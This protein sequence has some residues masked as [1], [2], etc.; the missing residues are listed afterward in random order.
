MV[1]QVAG[2][3]VIDDSRNYSGGAISSTDYHRITN[4]AGAS[5]I[6]TAGTLT[7]ALQITLP[8]GYTNTMLRMT[9][10]VY[11]YN[12]NQSFDIIC[13]GYNYATSPSW[14]NTFAYVIGNPNA[15]LF[16]NVRFGVTAAG[17]CCVYIG[18]LATAWSYPQ[19]YVSD[20]QI[21]Y[22]GITSAWM[23]GWSTSIQ[24]SAFEN[25][26]STVAAWGRLVAPDRQTAGLLTATGSLGGIEL[27]S[28]GLIYT[29]PGV[30]AASSLQPAAFMTFHRPGAF[31]G[32]FGLDN[33]NNFAIGGWSY[34]VTNPT[35]SLGSFKVGSFGVGTPASG[36]NGEIRATDNITAYYS[37]KRLKY[38]IRIIDGALNKVNQISGVTFQSN[39]EA[40]KY[41]YTDTKT[42]VGVIAQEIEEVLPEAVVPAPFDI[43]KNEDGTEYSKSGQNYMTVRYEKIVPLLIEAIKELKAELDMIKEKMELY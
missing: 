9:V 18:E 33:D 2:N 27:R 23:S 26:T 25:V 17:K 11:L 19:F 36:T 24:A 12:P 8:V 22:S 1:I 20:V 41:G 7:G 30:L 6:S 3:T 40:A 13:G 39:E 4:P 34:S 32:Y 14:V 37:D 28:S 42:Q 29:S 43:G 31:A 16:F 10:K 15:E 35:T 38:N 5:Y 21:G